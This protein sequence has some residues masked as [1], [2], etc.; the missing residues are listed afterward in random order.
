MKPEILALVALEDNLGRF[1]GRYITSSS[2][3]ISSIMSLFIGL[4][5]VFLIIFIIRRKYW[6]KRR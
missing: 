1:G 6:I 3:M 5:N 2:I 4:F